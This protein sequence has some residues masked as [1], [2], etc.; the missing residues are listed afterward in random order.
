MWLSR[1]LIAACLEGPLV[2]AAPVVQGEFNG[3]S[4]HDPR[5]SLCL[6]SCLDQYATAAAPL[7]DV[8][9]RNC[10]DLSSSMSGLQMTIVSIGA[11]VGPP[12]SGAIREAGTNYHNVSIF[13][14]FTPWLGFFREILDF[15]KDFVAMVIHTTY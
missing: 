5:H 11:L 10:E 3:W 12:I 1:V 4:R 9:A 7:N 15:E 13:A 6:G 14:V 2:A 8:A